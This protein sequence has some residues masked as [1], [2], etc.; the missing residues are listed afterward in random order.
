MR[1]LVLVALLVLAGCQNSGNYV[2]PPGQTSGAAGASRSHQ[3]MP[4]PK[5]GDSASTAQTVDLTT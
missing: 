5:S 1:W 4:A 3:K 2:Y